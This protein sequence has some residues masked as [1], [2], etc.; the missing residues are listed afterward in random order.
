M[1][2]N[3]KQNKAQCHQLKRCN[4]FVLGDD[5]CTGCRRVSQK[6]SFSELYPPRTIILQSTKKLKKNKNPQVEQC[7]N[8]C[9][10]VER[11]KRDKKYA[12]SVCLKNCKTAAPQNASENTLNK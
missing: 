2:K 8:H 11:I 10:A 1:Q 7:G 6:H 4:S 5:L 9:G 12:I 3:K